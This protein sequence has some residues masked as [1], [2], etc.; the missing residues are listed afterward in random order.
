MNIE[1][2]YLS[3]DT[4]SPSLCAVFPDQSPRK[5]GTDPAG[6]EYA[7]S[8]SS[9][10][11]A[12]NWATEIGH[13]WVQSMSGRWFKS[14]LAKM[15]RYTL[16]PLSQPPSFFFSDPSVYRLYVSTFPIHSVCF[17]SLLFLSLKFH[18]CYTVSFCNIVCRRLT[19][20]VLTT[21]LELAA[22]WSTYHQVFLKVVEHHCMENGY[23]GCVI[24]F[25][26]HIWTTFDWLY[27]ILHVA[28][29]SRLL[30]FITEQVMESFRF[31]T[32][33]SVS[34][35]M[36]LSIWACGLLWISPLRFVFCMIFAHVCTCTFR[37]RIS[38]ILETTECLFVVSVQ[39]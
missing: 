38:N 19:H 33:L 23:R 39:T 27:L 24:Q 21:E 30:M 6:V 15:S 35:I 17:K 34:L 7:T 10:G 8:W 11:R 36:M 22:I 25:S 32:E 9:V 12:S 29:I 16:H 20:W 4:A 18:H 13:K 31:L 2:I 1:S 14:M 37:L 26:R 5:N 3:I 28:F